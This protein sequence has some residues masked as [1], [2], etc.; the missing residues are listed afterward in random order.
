MYACDVPPIM[1]YPA[2]VSRNA[3]YACYMPPSMLAKPFHYMSNAFIRLYV[4]IVREESWKSK[5]S[6]SSCID[7]TIYMMICGTATN[8]QQPAEP[9]KPSETHLRTYHQHSA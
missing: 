3:H 8:C 7:C 4:A 6:Q 9:H 5:D 2:F 1:A